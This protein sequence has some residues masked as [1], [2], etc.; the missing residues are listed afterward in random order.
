MSENFISEYKLCFICFSLL[1]LPCSAEWW[2]KLFSKEWENNQKSPSAALLLWFLGKMDY[3]NILM[4]GKKSPGPQHN[5]CVS[6]ISL[7]AENDGSKVR[8]KLSLR[9]SWWK[10]WAPFCNVPSPSSSSCSSAGSKVVVFIFLTE[11]PNEKGSEKRVNEKPSEPSIAA[12]ER[13]Y[14]PNQTCFNCCY[15]EFVCQAK[16]VLPPYPPAHRRRT[17]F[18]LPLPSVG[19]K[20]TWGSRQ[21]EGSPMV[22]V[23][24]P[25]IFQDWEKDKC[26]CKWDKCLASVVVLN[27][28]ELQAYTQWGPF[29]TQHESLARVLC[30]LVS[31]FSFPFLWLSSSEW[32]MDHL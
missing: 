5:G 16:S 18:H 14:K 8:R 6:R 24:C 27:S 31:R 32:I 29:S 11:L 3:K 10:S 2:E 23:L 20:G 28:T 7:G 17:E 22:H 1:K 12:G 15:I 21:G 13:E 26:C 9:E 4:Q 25:G 19:L 30:S